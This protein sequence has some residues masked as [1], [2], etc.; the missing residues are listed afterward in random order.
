M[1]HSDLAAIR[2][3]GWTVNRMTLLLDS[4]RRYRLT[5]WRTDQNA[6]GIYQ[7]NG[8]TYTV[9]AAT[10]AAAAAELTAMLGLAMTT[11]ELDGTSR[12]LVWLMESNGHRVT[13]ERDGKV[14]IV[15]APD[16]FAVQ[17]VKRDDGNVYRAL[18]QLAQ[19]LGVWLID[20]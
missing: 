11:K 17:Q 6:G 3:A 12:A 10:M 19:A 8:P 9:E 15:S 20:G 7:G 18:C 5:A 1:M 14:V 13:I 16:R 2:A 4:G